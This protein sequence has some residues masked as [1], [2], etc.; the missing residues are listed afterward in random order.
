MFPDGAFA[1]PG[2][3]LAEDFDE[4]DAAAGRAPEA[5]FK[6]RDQRKSDFA[7]LYAFD[8]HCL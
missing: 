4:D 7:K 2:Q 6:R 5:G 8:F 1:P 3:P